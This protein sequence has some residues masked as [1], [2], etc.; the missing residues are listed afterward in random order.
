M[1]PLLLMQI[2]V[3][4]ENWLHCLWIMSRAP[5]NRHVLLHRL[6]NSFFL[7]SALILFVNTTLVFIVPITLEE[8]MF[9][10]SGQA[11]SDFLCNLIV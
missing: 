7:L 1:Q 3:A 5:P 10:D 4:E 8:S 11:S 9:V 6:R 2:T